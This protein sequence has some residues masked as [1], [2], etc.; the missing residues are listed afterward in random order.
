MYANIFA[1][2]LVDFRLGYY[3][4]LV[5]VHTPLSQY[6]PEAQQLSSGSRS[7]NDAKRIG[8]YVL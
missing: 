3:I 4:V 1:S 2:H 6:P 5:G 7:K 8:V